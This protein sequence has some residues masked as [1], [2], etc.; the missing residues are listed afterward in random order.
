MQRDKTLDTYVINLKKRK[1]R[2]KHIL[3]EF[4]LREEF[5]VRII[6]AIENKIGRLGLWLTIQ[7]IL[8]DFT[9]NKEFI[10]ICE[11][12]HTF[13]EE[14]NKDVLFQAIDFARDRNADILQGGISW[15]KDALQISP[16][17]FWVDRFTGC[18]FTVIFQR[19]YQA[20]LNA[21]F[22]TMDAADFKISDISSN[23]LVIH[24][25][26]SI[27]KEFGYSDVTSK[28]GN[29]P[30]YVQSLFSNTQEK[31]AQLK[32]IKKFYNI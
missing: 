11:D 5:N 20:I 28:N 23:K 26:I 13:T 31:L 24:P 8:T 14:Y 30:G 6:P 17:L 12:D 3:N 2:K 9:D 15:Y 22:G 29:T 16:G 19:F 1:D 27:Q 4:Q 32:M 21:Q 10:I 7:K 25:F 18:Q